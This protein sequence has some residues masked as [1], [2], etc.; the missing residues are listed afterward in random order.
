MKTLIQLSGGVG[1][2][3][4]LNIPK[5]YVLVNGR[6]IISYSLE[7]FMKN[8][9]IDNVVIVADESWVEFINNDYEKLAI[10]KPLYFAKAGKTRQHSI[11]NALKRI[12][13][14]SLCSDD[15]VI[16]I[17]D[18]ARPLVCDDI[19][20]ACIVELD[21]YDGV[22]P[23]IP[24]KDTIYLSKDGVNI[25]SLLTRSELFGGQAP[26][27]FR[28]GQYYAIHNVMTDDEIARINGSTEIAYKAGLNVRLVKGSEMNFKITTSEDLANFENILNQKI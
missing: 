5:Q 7:T 14:L 25:S 27:S 8:P 22:L 26:E 19:I 10:K 24:V 9:N 20:N 6:P 16:V 3:M 18:A 21:G 28:F 13:E 23:V 2:R 11:Y 17:H 4:G 15:D 12:K 1:S